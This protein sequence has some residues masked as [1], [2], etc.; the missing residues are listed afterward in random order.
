MSCNNGGNCAPQ[1][2]IFQE[3]INGNF[4]SITATV[5]TAD[6]G[7]YIQGTFEIFNSASSP[8][9]A[10]GTV[11]AVTF[12]VPTG[13]TVGRSVQSPTTFSIAATT[14]I[15]GSYCITLYKRVLP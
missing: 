14:G 13:Y 7:H 15:A 9:V 4:S 11:N 5:W 8:G 6:P 1:A 3:K 10:T 12:T 2:Q